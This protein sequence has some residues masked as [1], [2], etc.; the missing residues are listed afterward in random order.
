[1]GSSSNTNTNTASNSA[2]NSATNFATQAQQQT[3]SNSAGTYGQNTVSGPTQAA[4]NLINSSY[5]PITQDA[6]KNYT[7][8][9]LSDVVN[10]T[11]AQVQ[12]Q[13]VTQQQALK[14]NAISQNALGGNRMGIGMAQLMTGQG[15]NNAWTIA[16]LENSGYSQALSAAQADRTAAL[17]AA[18]MMGT[19]SSTAG[20]SSQATQG[21]TQAQSQGTQNTA[22][23]T[24]GTGTS[25][26]SSSTNPSL[27]SSGMGAGLG[28]LT[29][30]A[31]DGGA[32]RK[33]KDGGT[34]PGYDTGGGVS[35]LPNGGVPA[36]FGALQSIQPV[37]YQ[38]PQ[39]QSSNMTKQPSSSDMMKLGQSARSSLD[40]IMNSGS[41]GSDSVDAWDSGAASTGADAAG[42]DAAGAGADAAGAASGAGKG[43]MG[44]AD[45][46]AA[47][48]SGG[49]TAAA[50]PSVPEASVSSPSLQASM[51]NIPM[52]R[53]SA[54]TFASMPAMQPLSVSMPTV[55]MPTVQQAWT[56]Q[57]TAGKGSG[58]A[59]RGF[60]DG[61]GTGL[62]DA[63]G[64]DW[65]RL[66]GQ[67]PGVV[68]D[69]GAV[70]TANAI[71]AAA[72]PV[73]TPAPLSTADNV[74][75]WLAKQNG[76]AAPYPAD[77]GGRSASGLFQQAGIPQNAVIA[78]VPASP[79]PAT[80]APDQVPAG[81]GA[82]ALPGLMASDQDIGVM[83]GKFSG[84]AVNSSALGVQPVPQPS[85]Q[86][87]AGIGSL[88]DT[89][90]P[91][92]QNVGKRDVAQIA[93]DEFKSAGA[94]DN[95]TRGI[96]ANIK[97]ESNFDPTLRHFDQPNPRFRGT[98]AQNAHGLVQEGGDEWN[99]FDAWRKK[100][101]PDRPWT[102]PQLQARFVAQNLK[103]NYPST[104]ERMNKASPEDAA[105][106]FVSEYEKPAARYEAERR[107]RYGQ[108]VPELDALING[109]KGGIGAIAG[110]AWQV[111]QGAVNGAGDVVSG[112]G[113]GVSTLGQGLKNMVSKGFDNSGD[114]QQHPLQGG[115][116][117]AAGGLL[118]RVLGVNFNPLNLTKDERMT[119][120]SAAAAM[121]QPNGSVG[122]G[123]QAGLD[124]Q[125]GAQQ[126][127]RQAALDAMK[128]NIELA[129]LGQPQVMGEEIDPNTGQAHK[130]YGTPNMG[131]LPTPTWA[132][133]GVASAATPTTPNYLAPEVSAEDAVKMAPP[134]VATLAKKYANYELPVAAVSRKNPLNEQAISLAEKLHPG[135]SAQ[136]Y[137]A[138]QALNT[139][140]TSGKDA[141]EIKSYSTVMHHVASADSAV[142][143]MGNMQ[144]SWLNAPV[145][146]IRGQTSPEFIKAKAA[147]T[148]G[149]DTAIS[150][151]N[152]ATSGKPITVDERQHW[153]D[154]L[155]SN[156]SPEAMHATYKS[157]ME[158]IEGRMSETAA[159][160][161]NGMK[162]QPGDPKY[163]SPE[164][165][166]SPQALKEWKRLRGDTPAGGSGAGASGESSATT[167]PKTPAIGTVYKG[168]RFKGGDPAQPSSWATQ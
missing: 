50:A 75:N 25:S 121:L 84:P 77:T 101:Y 108:G 123:L 80:S 4:L 120:L 55:S 106:I 133:T 27:L 111:A 89:S 91:L 36:G 64:L 42:A 104:W 150:E 58:G 11:M 29:L 21:L 22:S 1:M 49:S 105:R 32:I 52:A 60:A 96:L 107:A 138:Q 34:V 5:G 74:N 157:F 114:Q 40:K 43:S 158:Y 129:K 90:G 141:D 81:I 37:Q 18:G 118:S 23:A 160:Y 99:N 88:Q 2:T 82:L 54:P 65:S 119:M 24:G 152:R 166:L 76:E 113:E 164:T 12:A 68:P 28:L 67:S 163:K 56:P 16:N 66:L 39:T 155:S 126:Q 146:A 136:E 15:L 48:A 156:S 144:S 45:M 38:P 31:R 148:T 142:D 26:S 57:A 159:K 83:P 72:E 95:A 149:I 61:G 102:D 47:F 6:I 137:K 63:D 51:P 112:V 19:Q 87:P 79:S 168:Y 115:K 86:A 122:A 9:Y 13:D 161:N 85:P 162:L 41:S 154:A 117:Q 167:M 7:N 132:R 135:F 46:A 93:A 69:T 59:V 124:Y 17:Q 10:S 92:Y 62:D 143:A 70:P 103:E 127:Q 147:A 110:G 30:M 151:Y 131:G 20:M 116:D 78:P 8:P 125:R 33:R 140:F 153:R 134:A 94:T 139:G 44:A 98:E 53:A 109:A 145:N 165:M 73:Y 128:I 97:D 35:I 71:S 14:G 100:N 130:I 3:A